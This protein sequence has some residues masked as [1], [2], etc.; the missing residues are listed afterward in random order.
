MRLSEMLAGAALV[1]ATATGA[2]WSAENV[3]YVVRGNTHM[4]IGVTLNEA[5]VRERLPAGLEPTAGVT[6][7]LQVYTSE[8]GEGVAAY[9]RSYVWA[10][11]AG[12]D[13]ITGNPGR[14]ILWVVDTAQAEKLSGLGYDA[15]AGEATLSETEGTLTGAAAVAG[16]QVLAASLKAGDCAAGTGVINYPSMPVWA[17]GMAV[18][19]YAFAGDFCGGE[20][21]GMEITA[22]EGHALTKLAPQPA[23]WVAVARDL[24]FSATPAMPLPKTE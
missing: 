24:S 20:L 16:S 23:G 1:L 4:L 8:G 9:T 12:M 13:S 14:Y 6:G 19:Q 3:P 7:G 2:G 22:P 21:V 10:D 17:E 15:T 18:T 5:A 11:L